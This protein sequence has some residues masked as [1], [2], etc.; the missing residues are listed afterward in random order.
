M[1]IM[2]NK[3]KVAKKKGAEVVRDI[4]EETD[5]YGTVKMSTVKIVSKKL[6]YDT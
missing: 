3:K 2:L 5:E 1:M 6:F 4:W